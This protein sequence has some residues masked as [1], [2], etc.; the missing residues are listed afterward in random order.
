MTNKK[1]GVAML[2]FL[3][4]FL[5]IVGGVTLFA[6]PFFHFHAPWNSQN[7]SLYNQRYQNDGITRHF[8][9]DAI[10]TGSS[11]TENFKTT[12]MDALFGTTSIK[13]P[14]SGATYKELNDVLAKAIERNPQI[15]TI[16]R[17][18]D[19]EFIMNEKDAMAHK[20]YPQYLYDDNLFNDTSYLFNKDILLGDT[21]PALVQMIKKKPT[22]TFDEYSNWNN[23]YPYGI[24]RIKSIYNRA[25]KSPETIPFSAEDEKNVRENIA[26][27]VTALADANPQIDF[28]YFLTPYSVV[29][30]DRW[31]QRGELER[32]LQAQQLAVELILEHENIHLFSFLDDFQTVSNLDNYRDTMHY[33][34]DINSAML[35]AMKNGEHQLTKENCQG[36]FDEVYAFY[37]MY[38]YDD[39][40]Q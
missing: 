40:F 10:I 34:E 31:N 27:N 35:C 29:Y 1:M 19:L 37:T 18:L 4:A 2:S 30:W 9:Y 24:E 39:I 26:Q 28:Y 12:E 36:Y 38:P 6:D 11:M 23:K 16:V 7:Y 15:T 21:Y 8:D 32:N 13:I 5:L 22:T 25:P 17:G 33:S 14:F 20:D 3:L